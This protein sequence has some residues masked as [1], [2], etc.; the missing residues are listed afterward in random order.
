MRAEDVS[1]AAAPRDGQ[2]GGT[3]LPMESSRGTLAAIHERKVQRRKDSE[4]RDGS[5]AGKGRIY[6]P[7]TPII[8]HV[9]PLF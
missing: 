9:F 4:A 1:A 7:E 2:V 6:V 5:E 3:G 8:F